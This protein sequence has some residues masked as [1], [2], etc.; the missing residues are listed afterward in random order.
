L[1]DWPTRFG[2]VQNGFGVG[3]G[4]GLGV[5]VGVA[6]GS[7]VGVGVAFG[8]GVGVGVGDGVGD[9]VGVGEG[10][11]VGRTGSAGTPPIDPNRIGKDAEAVTGRPGPRMDPMIGVMMLN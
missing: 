11:G 7:G 2:T 3:V 8:S 9:G 1:V 5:G 10:V 4:V 6:F